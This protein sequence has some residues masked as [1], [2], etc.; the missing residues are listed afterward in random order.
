MKLS[1]RY[2]LYQV[3]LRQ[4]FS[5]MGVDFVGNLM[6]NGKLNQS[7][8]KNTGAELYGTDRIHYSEHSHLYE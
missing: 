1:A 4:N 5:L 2:D 7:P 3:T 6:L 8:D